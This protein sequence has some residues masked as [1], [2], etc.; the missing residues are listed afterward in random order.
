[1][2]TFT[3]SPH[4]QA[5]NE[6]VW[7]IVRQIPAGQVTSYGQ[8]AAMIPAPQGMDPKS[9]EAFASRWV[10]GAM[11]ICPN[12][13]PWQ[14]VINSQGK[15]SL[16]PGAEEQRQLLEEEGVVFNERG[17]VDLKKFGWQGPPADWLRR[18]GFF[19]PPGFGL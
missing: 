16:R 10:G 9:Y 8:I 6:R 11:A 18:H 19:P 14:R 7:E 13:V 1:M 3:S 2:P 15:L 12:E 5:F 4:T 17:K